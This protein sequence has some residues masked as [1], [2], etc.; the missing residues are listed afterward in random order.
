VKYAEILKH[1]APCGLDCG[2]CAD[3]DGGEIQALST[4]LREL[5]GNYGRVAALKAGGRPE[6][7]GF[8]EFQAVLESLGQGSCGGCRTDRVTCP[9]D[10]LA[11]TCSREK[12]VDFCFQCPDYPC[13]GQF[14][15][16]PLRKRWMQLSDRM[17]QIGVEA[18]FEEQLATHRYPGKVG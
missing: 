10:C 2:R 5:L 1:L 3:L 6:F 18:F 9:L 4:R 15:G 12:G 16:M 17:R 8:E 13:E 7:A 14:A 11:R